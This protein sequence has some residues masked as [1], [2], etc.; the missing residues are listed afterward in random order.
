MQPTSETSDS[1]TPTGPYTPGP[2][3]PPTSAAPW[4][5]PYQQPAPPPSVYP[6]PPEAYQQPGG[7]AAPGMYPPPPAWYQPGQVG[8]YPYPPQSP[9]P[10]YPPYA[11]YPYP[12]APY[13]PYPP[14]AAYP[15]QW[16]GQA[17]QWPTA[18]QPV[19]RR[20]M[21]PALSIILKL[22]SALVSF[23]LYA[24]IWGWQFGLGVM[25]MLFVHEMGHYIVIRAKGMPAGLP[26]FIPLFGAF[27]TLRQMPKNVRDEAEIGIAGPIAGAF[28]G[29]A[30]LVIYAFTGLG[31]LIPLAYFSFWL[32][33]LNLIPVSPLDGSRVTSAI[34]KWI[35]PI[36]LVALGVG[37]WFTQNFVLALLFGVGIFQMISRF[38]AN[39]KTPYY[40]ISGGSRILVT[41]MY[42]GL[43]AALALL[44]YILQPMLAQSGF[45]FGL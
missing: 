3:S 21:S 38:R 8:A 27:V 14:Q 22:A 41:L 43:I 18:A 25:V 26:T 23:W 7:P 31:V 36:G 20:G 32:N 44:C 34:T 33:L 39:E 5:S 4:P 24:L 19:A 9:Y 29:A 6:P 13:P 10:P 40:A 1:S 42:F 12:P 15:Q 35:W 2:Y 17:A 11:Q 37:A 28:V 30:F 45:A 16:A